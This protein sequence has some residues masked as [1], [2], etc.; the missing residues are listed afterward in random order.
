[1]K[2]KTFILSAAM[3]LAAGVFAADKLAGFEFSCFGTGCACG[4]FQGVGEV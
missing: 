4:V 3:L 2:I 1:M